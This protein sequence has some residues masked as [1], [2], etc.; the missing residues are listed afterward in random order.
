MTVRYILIFSRNR[1]QLDCITQPPCVA[2]SGDSARVSVNYAIINICHSPGG[3]TTFAKRRHDVSNY[4]S[5]VS[6]SK[7]FMKIRSAVP[8]H[9]CLIVL[10]DGKKQ[11]NNCKTYTHPPPTGRR[12]RKLD[13]VATLKALPLKSPQWGFI[14]S[15][16]G[17]TVHRMNT[18][19]Y[20]DPN[21]SSAN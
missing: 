11:K 6:F 17:T 8:E 5:P 1:I 15:P 20:S 12:L 4:I 10:A 16:N 14:C 7:S 3:G 9:G 2:P 18:M 13:G 21:E 19:R